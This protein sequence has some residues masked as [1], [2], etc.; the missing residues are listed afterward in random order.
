MGAKPGV[1]LYFSIREPLQ[2]LTLEE[3]GMLLDAVLEYGGGG[4]LP[5]FGGCLGMAWAFVRQQIDDDTKRYNDK[6]EKNK[7]AVANRW[8]K[9]AEEY[10]RIHAYTNDTNTISNYNTNSNYNTI[11]NINNISSSPNKSGKRKRLFEKDSKPYKCAVYLDECIRD[12][13]STKKPATEA[14]LQTWADAFDKLNRIDGQEWE[15]IADVLEWSQTDAFWSQNIMSGDKFRKQFFTL[16][17][18]CGTKQKPKDYYD[19]AEGDSL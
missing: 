1:M 13:L 4:S 10:E 15:L 11:S 9:K 18:K 12:R 7:K 8:Q 19:C 16:L 14:T 5:V 2:L 17:A 6:C 3:K